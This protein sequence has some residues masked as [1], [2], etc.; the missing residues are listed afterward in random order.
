MEYLHSQDPIII[1]RDLKVLVPLSL[2][3]SLSLSTGRSTSTDIDIDIG[4]GMGM[5]SKQSLNLLVM[6]DMTVKVRFVDQSITSLSLSLSLSLS[7]WLMIDSDERTNE[8]TNEWNEHSDFG[9]SKWI[10]QTATMTAN[11]G[12]AMWSAPEVLRFSKYSQQADI[13]RHDIL[14]LSLS[15]IDQSMFL[16]L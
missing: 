2:P 3:L 9:T 1:H 10:Q 15:L 14:S 11:V 7:R 8:R 12:S 5:G 4:M 13:Y 6:S 16:S